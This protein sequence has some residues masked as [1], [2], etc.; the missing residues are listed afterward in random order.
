[1]DQKTKTVGENEPTLNPDI[2]K[3][4]EKIG[5]ETITVKA[6]TVKSL[7]YRLE[8]KT[9]EGIENTDQ[10]METETKIPVLI[11]IEAPMVHMNIELSETNIELLQEKLSS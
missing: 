8:N 9:E 11:K 3:K 10:Y 1:M 5:T 6:G 2:M 7:H 4:G